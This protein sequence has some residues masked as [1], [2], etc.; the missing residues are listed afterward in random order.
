MSS[1]HDSDFT[2]GY[3]AGISQGFKLG[4]IAALASR[5]MWVL[6]GAVAFALI[7]AL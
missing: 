2:R 1:T 5:V 4:W 6:V 7:K 3:S